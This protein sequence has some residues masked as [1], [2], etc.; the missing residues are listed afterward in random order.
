MRIYQRNLPHHFVKSIQA[1]QTNTVPVTRQSQ[2]SQRDID[3]EKT[4]PS[5]DTPNVVANAWVS[6]FK[7]LVIAMQSLV[8]VGRQFFWAVNAQFEASFHH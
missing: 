7:R 4:E 6:I 1:S 5:S 2:Y 3:A 8:K